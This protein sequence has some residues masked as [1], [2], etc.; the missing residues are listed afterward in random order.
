MIIGPLE[1]VPKRVSQVLTRVA[2]ADEAM[3]TWK[4]TQRAS[5]VTKAPI[6]EDLSGW[7]K[8]MEQKTGT[9]TRRGALP[10]QKHRPNSVTVVVPV[11]TTSV[12]VIAD[13]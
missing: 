7:E 13:P 8:M 3:K 1:F 5:R 11:D 2:C 9:L 10:G 4:A 6:P 12:D